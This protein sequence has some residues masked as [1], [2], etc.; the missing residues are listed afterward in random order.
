M[1]R[2]VG[3]DGF[4]PILAVGLTQLPKVLDRKNEGN[5]TTADRANIFGKLGDDTRVAKLIQVEGEIA[6]K[7]SAWA[8]GCPSHHGT[9]HLHNETGGKRFQAL[10]F[11]FRNGQKQGGWAVNHTGKIEVVGAGDFPQVRVIEKEKAGQHLYHNAT[12][13]TII[14]L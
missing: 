7:S 5:A 12:C 4:S 1:R 2:T 14:F 9:H 3:K 8:R 10:G 6:G 11:V 13:Q